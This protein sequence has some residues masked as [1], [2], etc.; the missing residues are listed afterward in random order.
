MLSSSRELRSSRCAR[1]RAMNSPIW[2]PN[3]S[4]S[5]T[6]SSSGCI[7]SRARISTTPSTRSP[8]RI[9]KTR[10]LRSPASSRGFTFGCCSSGGISLI[11]RACRSAQA[12]PGRRSPRA[13]TVRS[14]SSAKRRARSSSSSTQTAAGLQELLARAR[15]ARARRPPSRAP[16]RSPRA[17]A[18]RPRRSSPTSPAP[19]P[20]AR[21]VSSRRSVRRRAT[22]SPTPAAIRPKSSISEGS[23]PR[24]SRV[25][26]PREPTAPSRPGIGAVT[27]LRTPELQEAGRGREPGLAPGGPR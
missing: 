3:R 4:Q 2:R 7:T 19:R 23:K 10:T 6:S 18:A 27:P 14:V 12:R 17:V 20:T 16:R 13:N 21:C 9:G 1:S 15:R 24:R 22:A 26:A 5:S 8:L 11:Q 25:Q